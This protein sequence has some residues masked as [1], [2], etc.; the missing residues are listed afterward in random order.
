MENILSK[1]QMEEIHQ[2]CKRYY[3]KNYKIN[4][5]G[6]IDVSQDVEVS[7]MELT[8]L[9]E[10][11]LV[12]R[13]VEGRFICS[14]NML[15]NLLGAPKRIIGSLL[16]QHNRLTT[17]EGC[18][19][20]VTRV[21]NCSENQLTSLEHMPVKVWNLMC[22]KNKLATM[23]YCAKE[24]ENVL[25]CS[26]NELISLKGVPSEMNQFKCSENQLTSLE[27]GPVSVADVF[28][29]SYN[30]LENFLHAPKNIGFECLMMD[31]GLPWEFDAFRKLSPE[32]KNVFL[33][34]Q[35]YH[36]I[37]TPDLNQENL[38]DFIKEIRDGLR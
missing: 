19:S 22:R 4:S 30:K 27:Y 23:E 2:A 17:L 28:D 1:S 6:S 8:D 33:K 35:E 10:L 18:P 26:K 7:G 20:Q 34:Y 37:W 31:T 11:G 29:I 15:T 14:G 32:Q 3:I 36:D 9:G 25:D 38:Y 13:V 16:C 5:D 12:F 21:F 24:I